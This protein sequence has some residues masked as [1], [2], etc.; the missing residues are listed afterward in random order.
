MAFH[1]NILICLGLSLG[2]LVF[3]F[4]RAANHRAILVS[5]ALACFTAGVVVLALPLAY[6]TDMRVTS[7]AWRVAG[8]VLGLFWF[9]SCLQ[10]HWRRCTVLAALYGLLFLVAVQAII[11]GQQWLVPDNAW[12]SLYGKRVYGSFFQPNVLA[13]FI[14]TGVTLTLAL[15]LLPGLASKRAGSE[16]ARQCGLLILLAMLSAVLICI[17]SRAGWLGG[18]AAI[19]LLFRFGRLNSPR[20]LRAVAALT[21]GVCLGGTL[22]L[23]GQSLIP[24]IDH[25]HSNL[26]RWTMLRDTLAMIADR[27]WQGWGYGGFEY[28]FQHFRVSQASPTQVTEIARHPHNEI[29]LWAVEGGLMGLT[30]MTLVLIGIGTIV[31][32]AIK[33]D[34]SA[35]RAGHR[36]AGVT[37]ALSIAALPMAIHSLLEF[38]FYLSTLHFVIFLLML[39]MADRLSA[40]KATLNPLPNISSRILNRTLTVLAL[41]ITVLASFTLKGAVTLTQVERFGMEDVAPLKTLPSLTRQLLQE[42]ITFDE[43]VGA[44]MTYNRTRDERLLENYSQWAQTYLQQRIDKNV[45]A[46]LISVLLHQKHSATAERYRREAAL[47]FPTDVRFSPPS[48]DSTATHNKQE[49][50]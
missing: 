15:L 6:T 14:A 24:L 29:L 44:L 4:R 46:N 13:S 20:T 17:Q 2:L 31:R 37:T 25:A 34:R 48:V 16:R 43:Q 27:P 33:R 3:W 45:Y 32:Q 10:I 23:L 5:P 47:F 39:A 41:G 11:A 19:V 12:V 36:M 42:R 22:L 38:P 18:I 50:Q 1:V 8:T 49:R 21:G 9:V 35:L 30:G 40:T 7:A 28:D 26:S